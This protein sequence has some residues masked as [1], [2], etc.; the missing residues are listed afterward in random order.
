MAGRVAGKVA[1]ISGVA[2]G[3][4]RSHALRLA[5]EGADIIGI[6]ICDEVGGTERFYPHATDDDLAETVKLVE[7]LDR[8]IVATKADVRDSAAVQKA[9]DDGVAELG[10]LDIVAANAGIFQFGDSVA[11][12]ST[13]DWEEI[14]QTNVTGVFHTC[15]AAIPHLLAGSGD[16]SIVL[17]AS[18]TGLKGFGYIGHYTAAKHAVIGLMRSLALE[19]GPASIRVNA[20]AP[21]TVNTTMV[22]NDP[23]YRLF[24]PD[25]D[26]PTQ[27]DFASTMQT[28]LVLP[29]PWVEPIDVSNAVLF[30]ASEEARYITGH[31]LPVDAGMMAK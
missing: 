20:V 22:Q 23:M 26:N 6:D 12:T 5:E 27:E 25:K 31:T 18:T 15:K 1:F 16:R 13:Q 29:V 28:L 7:K 9:V 21:T 30:L 19:L 24:V 17:T 8:R 14:F 10:R 11:Q 2:R 3:Q 4:G